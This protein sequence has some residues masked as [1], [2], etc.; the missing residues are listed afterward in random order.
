MQY[1]ESSVVGTIE[2]DS[3]HPV[4]FD[5]VA[6]EGSKSAVHAAPRRPLKRRVQFDR[7]SDEPQIDTV[8]VHDATTD[9]SPVIAFRLSCENPPG[10]NLIHADLARL[11]A[12]LDCELRLL[13]ARMAE[14]V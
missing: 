9:D 13:R 2:V 1:T 4:E 14:R 8:V 7:S 12:D 5:P 11:E 3:P 6:D 10:T